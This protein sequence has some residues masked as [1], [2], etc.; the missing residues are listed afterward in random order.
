MEKQNKHCIIPGFFVHLVHIKLYMKNQ[1]PPLDNSMS[2]QIKY[3]LFVEKM[4]NAQVEYNS[5]KFQNSSASE[6]LMLLS[7]I[8]KI[9]ISIIL[10]VFSFI[11]LIWLKFKI[12]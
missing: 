3:D 1:F 7:G 5:K 6:T 10:I 2:S 9:L 4:N 8:F 12:K 11:R